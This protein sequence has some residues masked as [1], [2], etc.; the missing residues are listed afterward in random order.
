MLLQGGAADQLGGVQQL[1]TPEQLLEAQKLV[2]QL[3]VSSAVVSYLQRLAQYSRDS[4]HF[5]L[6]LSPGAVWRY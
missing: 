2:S 1:L 4:Q 6:G 3:Q 5:S